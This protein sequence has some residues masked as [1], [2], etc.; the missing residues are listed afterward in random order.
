M[1][2]VP[3]IRSLDIFATFP[4]KHGNEIDFWNADKHE[5]EVDRIS[6]GVRS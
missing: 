3:Q 1:P 2:K 6:L 4:E 5:H